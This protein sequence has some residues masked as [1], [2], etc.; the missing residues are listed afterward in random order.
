MPRR[1]TANITRAPRIGDLE[2][3]DELHALHHQEEPQ[4]QGK[5]HLV[6]LSSARVLSFGVWRMA[7][8][9]P[10]SPPDEEMNLLSDQGGRNEDRTRT[11]FLGFPRPPIDFDFDF[12]FDWVLL[13]LKVPFLNAFSHLTLRD[14]D[15]FGH[16]STHASVEDCP[17]G[18]QQDLM[19]IPRKGTKRGLA[20][21]GK[22]GEGPR[23]ACRTSWLTW[24]H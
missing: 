20:S 13:C 2:R 16:H 10:T 9:K 15:T 7:R 11:P 6:I 22:S 14:P 18:M 12:D 17:Q 8:N 4:G 23:S 3:A 1:E 5:P 21:R 24:F 19:F